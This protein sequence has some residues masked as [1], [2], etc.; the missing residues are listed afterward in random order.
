MFSAPPPEASPVRASALSFVTMNKR[1][2][3][4]VDYWKINHAVRFLKNFFQIPSGLEDLAFGSAIPPL[5]V[6]KYEMVG[7]HKFTGAF[8]IKRSIL[9]ATYVHSIAQLNTLCLT[10]ADSWLR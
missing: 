8:I 6:K 5:F 9:K 2:L 1:C 10:F 3:F 7:W 4:S